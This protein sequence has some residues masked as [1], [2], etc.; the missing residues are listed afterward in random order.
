MRTVYKI[1]FTDPFHQDAKGFA[2][3]GRHLLHFIGLCIFQPEGCKIRKIL[4]GQGKTGCGKTIINIACRGFE[5]GPGA[6]GTFCEEFEGKHLSKKSGQT[7]DVAHDLRWLMLL[8][9]GR[10]FVSSE[11]EQKRCPQH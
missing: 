1:L 2:S 5:S 4:F 8:K 11:L 10:L 6:F 3:H 9:H 7:G